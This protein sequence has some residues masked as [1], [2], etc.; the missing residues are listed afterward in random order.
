V[1]PGGYGT[2]EEMF[3]MVTWRQLGLHAK[4]VGL[5]N[6]AGYFDHLLGFLAHAQREQ[7][8]RPQ[9][10]HLLSVDAGIEA[11]LGRLERE[12]GSREDSNQESGLDRS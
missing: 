4:P 7:F 8:I 2:F 1:L 3:E 5:L 12:L 6:V 11:L 10:R 9:H